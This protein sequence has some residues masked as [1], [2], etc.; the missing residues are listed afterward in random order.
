MNEGM[1]EGIKSTRWLALVAACLLVAAVVSAG[2][3]GFGDGSSGG[4]LVSAAGRTSGTVEVPTTSTVPPTTL[5]PSPSTTVKTPTTLP[6]AASAVLKAIGTTAPPTTQPPAPTTTRPPVVTTVPPVTP[7]TT[8]ATTTTVAPRRVVT[9]TVANEHTEPFV[10]TINGRVFDLEA[11]EVE[12]PV[13]VTLRGTAGDED[14]VEARARISADPACQLTDEGAFF[15]AGGRYRVAVV[16]GLG[17]C[18]GP[19]PFLGPEIVITPQP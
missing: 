3:L 16:P 14:E 5:P 2:A 12:D 15:E 8:P 18:P 7:T 9:I 11:G 10:L 17:Q 1:Q 6:Q 13:E 4:G 19:P